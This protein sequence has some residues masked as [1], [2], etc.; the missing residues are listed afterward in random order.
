MTISEKINVTFFQNVKM[1]KRR[2]PTL[3]NEAIQPIELDSLDEVAGY[4]GYTAEQITQTVDENEA[5]EHH[6]RWAEYMELEGE[7][8]NNVNIDVI[9][10]NGSVY[11]CHA[12]L[13]WSIFGLKENILRYMKR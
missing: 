5:V 3:H 6:V 2:G 9:L 1:E 12:L 4:C 13:S 7:D 10:P 11:H 8:K